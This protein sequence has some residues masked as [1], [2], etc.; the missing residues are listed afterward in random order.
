MKMLKP[1]YKAIVT[2]VFLLKN[3][4]PFFSRSAAQSQAIS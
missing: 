4:S 1:G 3:L 2:Y